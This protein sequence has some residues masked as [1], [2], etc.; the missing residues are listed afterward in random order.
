MALCKLMHRLT[1]DYLC[2][3]SES[4]SEGSVQTGI[5]ITQLLCRLGRNEMESSFTLEEM[6][7][8]RSAALG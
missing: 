1:L 7:M 3:R 4:E 6:L 5:S 8:T 2:E